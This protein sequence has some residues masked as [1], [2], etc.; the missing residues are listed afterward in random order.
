LSHNFLINP[1]FA[2]ILT[3]GSSKNKLISAS[4]KIQQ[5]NLPTA[6]KV[7]STKMKNKFLVISLTGRNNLI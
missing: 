4:G 2:Q 7:Y 5:K 3:K 1:G 6:L